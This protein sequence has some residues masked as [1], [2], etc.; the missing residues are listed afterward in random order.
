MAHSL[1]EL[2]LQRN[3]MGRLVYVDE[4]GATH[5][6][7]VPVRAFPISEP[8]GGL[9]LMSPDGH[10]LIWIADPQAL[11]PA[12][13]E[14][15]EAELAGREFMPEIQ[16]LVSVSTYATPSTWKVQTDRGEVSFVLRG[17]EDI[18]RLAGHTLLITDSH[19]IHYLIRDAQALDRASRKLLDRF[20]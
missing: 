11:A 13:R 18:R 15:I 1:S 20:L 16:R 17:E 19:G 14:L 7:V 10:E 12:V 2:N 6:G 5:D 3:A 8:A 4:A 9:S